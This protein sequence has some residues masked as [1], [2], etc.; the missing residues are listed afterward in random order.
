[1]EDIPDTTKACYVNVGSAAI[2]DNVVRKD[3][4]VQDWEIPRENVKIEKIIGKGAFCQVAKAFV[5]GLGTVAVKMIRGR[6]YSL[7]CTLPLLIMNF[8]NHFS[9]V[10]CINMNSLFLPLC[11]F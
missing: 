1:M 8:I 6:L 10:S 11:S 5:E 9:C 4:S 7:S 3:E 2:Y